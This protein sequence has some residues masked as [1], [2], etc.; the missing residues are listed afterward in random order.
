MPFADSA[1]KI[2]GFTGFAPAADARRDAL[3]LMGL[4]PGVQ[5]VPDNDRLTAPA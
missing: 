2:K 5:P 1:V 3:G 4:F